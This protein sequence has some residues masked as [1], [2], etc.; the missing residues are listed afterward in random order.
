M[1]YHF[2]I[3]GCAR[4]FSESGSR[5]KGQSDSSTT[6]TSARAQ[7]FYNNVSSH[8]ENILRAFF[9]AINNHRTFKQ[10]DR[11]DCKFLRTHPFILKTVAT[12][13][14]IENS[15]MNIPKR[16]ISFRYDDDGIS[17]SCVL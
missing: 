11:V 9:K 12:N 17:I 16:T 7:E 10:L 15:V 1:L 4:S 13:T 6:H 8:E 3:K 14:K 5:D 2:I